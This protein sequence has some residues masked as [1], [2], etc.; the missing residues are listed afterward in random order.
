MATSTAVVTVTSLQRV[1]YA[2]L[3]FRVLPRSSV[4]L[5]HSQ[6][7]WVS[8]VGTA[9]AARSILARTV[10]RASRGALLVLVEERQASRVRGRARPLSV[11]REQTQTTCVQMGRRCGAQCRRL[12][13]RGTP[14]AEWRQ[15][16][17]ALPTARPFA[18]VASSGP[19][20]RAA[21]HRGRGAFD[22]LR[23]TACRRDATPKVPV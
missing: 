7:Q 6:W 12:A 5:P 19:P 20:P 2:I 8:A 13:L 15:V 1:E 4:S 17:D 14:G 22:P 11:P 18:R 3:L 9:S 21:S 23:A 16:R 10:G